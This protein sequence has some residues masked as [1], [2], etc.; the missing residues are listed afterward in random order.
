MNIF[1]ALHFIWKSKDISNLNFGMRFVCWHWFPRY[2]GRNASAYENCFVKYAFRRIL[3]A[4]RVVGHWADVV[5]VLDIILHR[6]A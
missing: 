1:I 6:I 3:P 5:C 4:L 2:I